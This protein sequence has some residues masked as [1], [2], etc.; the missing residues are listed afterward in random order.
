MTCGE[1]DA[2]DVFQSLHMLEGLPWGLADGDHAVAIQA[3]DVGG[4]AESWLEGGLV[5][6][7]EQRGKV[8]RPPLRYT[9]TSQGDATFPKQY[10]ALANA[11]LDEVRACYGSEGLQQIVRGVA[12]RLATSEEE[13]VADAS[14][15]VRVDAVVELLRSRGV[16]A[17]WERSGDAY[18]LHERTCPYPEVARRNSVACAMDVAQVREL[19]GMDARLTACVVRGDACCTYRLLPIPAN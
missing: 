1:G 12:T 18:L 7:F 8:G 9:L 13:V 17:D 6:S 15:D 2:A 16:V 5:A 3:K 14:P 10:D 4:R 19:S 11:L